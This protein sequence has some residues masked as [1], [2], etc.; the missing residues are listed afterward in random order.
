MATPT[1]NR[2]TPK[3]EEIRP[4]PVADTPE[5]EDHK[6]RALARINEIRGTATYQMDAASEFDLPLDIIPDGWTYQWCRKSTLGR[7]DTDNMMARLATGWAPV[8]VKR[9]AFLMPANWAGDYIERKGLILMEKPTVLVQ[10]ARERDN[11]EAL[12]AVRNKEEALGLTPQGE[13][14]RDAH[15]ETRPKLTKTVSPVAI[16]GD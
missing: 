14:P 7:E 2:L 16:P 6:A 4:S 5:V 1:P 13:L 12:D 15:P 8:P 3:N 9:H 10:E 11:R